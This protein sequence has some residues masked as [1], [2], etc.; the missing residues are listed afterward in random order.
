MVVEKNKPT[1]SKGVRPR[2]RKIVLEKYNYQCAKCGYGFLDIHHIDG[3][4]SNDSIDNLIPLCKKC[5]NEVHGNRYSVRLVQ[6]P[7]KLRKMLKEELSEELDQIIRKTLSNLKINVK[8][9]ADINSKQLLETIEL[10]SKGWKAAS[11]NRYT[12]D[13]AGLERLVSELSENVIS[14]LSWKLSREILRRIQEEIDAELLLDVNQK[15]VS[16]E[17]KELKFVEEKMEGEKHGEG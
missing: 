12:I 8:I 4:P 9:Q 16:L 5:H 17:E 14:V 13:V 3:D 11:R 2:I 10:D 15:E 6:L 7:H 1:R